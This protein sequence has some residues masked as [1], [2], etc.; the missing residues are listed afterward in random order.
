[1]SYADYHKRQIGNR[2]LH[3]ET[4]MMSFGYS[5]E[6][7]EGAVKAPIFLSSTFV[8]E[9][10]QDG[11]DFFDITSGRREARPDE[12][13]GLIYSRFNNPNLELLEDR[14]SLWERAETACVFSSGMA[15]ISSAILAHLK[16]GDT[17]LMSEPL[18]GGTA[19]LVEKILPEFGI[20]AFG[21]CNGTDRAD[22]EA[23]AARATAAGSVGMILLETP[24]NPTNQLVDLELVRAIADEIGA[25]T[26]RMP[27]IAVD[28]TFLGPLFQHPLLHGVDLV[29]YSL[30]KYVG[31]HSDLVSGAVVG[32]KEHVA[33]VRGMRNFL[34]NQPDAH[35]CWMLTRSLETLAVRMERSNL[36]ARRVAEFLINHPKVARV[37]YLGFLQT[38]DPQKAVF[39][40]QCIEP[41]ST[42]SFDVKGDEAAAFR[43]LDGL[44]LIKL[45]VSLGGTESLT[46]HPASTTHSGI[47]IEDR[48]RMGINDSMIRLSIGIEHSDDLIADLS[49][50]LDLV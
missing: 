27:I 2:D 32:S 39:D 50:A 42:F 19:T 44:Q 36:N 12:T 16:P 17:L 4:Q 40:K 37:N 15:A 46:C 26:G 10:A 18:Y 22:I 30:T 20:H 28:N 25:K 6:F 3:P 13:N 49:H 5:P 45:A 23:A 29:L 1:M 35:T 41:G 43:C 47:P 9:T 48:A 38:D 8:F 21:F 11:K 34:G 24:A 31:G 14:L 33:P 7:S